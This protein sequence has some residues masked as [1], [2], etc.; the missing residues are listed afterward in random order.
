MI[1]SSDTEMFPVGYRTYVSQGDCDL[2]L[3][4]PET[5]LKEAVTGASNPLDLLFEA[6]SQL[7]R[8]ERYRSGD[9]GKARRRRPASRLRDKV[10]ADREIQ[11]RSAHFVALEAI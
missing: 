8:P 11:E 1:S 10:C 5:Y 6:N 9:P 7:L 3:G 4:G 2:R